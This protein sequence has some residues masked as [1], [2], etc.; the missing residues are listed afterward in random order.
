M[1]FAVRSRRRASLSASAYGS[2]SNSRELQSAYLCGGWERPAL[3][4][5]FKSMPV[6]QLPS[7]IGGLMAAVGIAWLVARGHVVPLEMRFG[8]VA[9]AGVAIGLLWRGRR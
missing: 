1:P 5:V 4:K 3:W 7:F 6:Q 8:V 9:A 2:G